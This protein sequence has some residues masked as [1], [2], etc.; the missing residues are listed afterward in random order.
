MPNGCFVVLIPTD[1]DY[2]VMGYY[3]K[4]G[5]SNFEITNDLFLRLNLDHSKNDYNLLKLKE[6][7][8]LSYIYKLKGKLARRASGIIIGLLMTEEDEVDKFRSAL[9]EAAEALEMP[10]LNILTKSR[11]EFEIILKDIYFEH[12][13]PLIDILQPEALKNNII[14]ITKFMLSGGKKER[15]IAQDLLIKVE[16]GEH[17]KIS[18]FYKIAESAIKSLDYEKAAKSYKKAAELAEELYIMDI[19]A[20]LKEKGQFSQNIPELSREREK[21]VQEARNA[22]RNEDFHTAYTS[23]RKASEISKKLVQFDK[24]EEFRL[25]SKALEDFYKIDQKYKAE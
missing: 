6:E 14:N 3:F 4:E 23:Y 1:A 21:I 2:K 16:N 5:E 24:E 19:A 18:D 7:R 17:V 13:E 12:L 25:K 22:L 15:K 8:I 10:S 9:K 11:E 20:S